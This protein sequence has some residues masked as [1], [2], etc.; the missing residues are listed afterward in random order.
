MHEMFKQ[1]LDIF[2]SQY[3]D[4]DVLLESHMAVNDETHK[5]KMGS[6]TKPICSDVGM[7][8]T[9]SAANLN[10][11]LTVWDLGLIWAR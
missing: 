1:Q 7:E 2:Q 11:E 8:S 5:I 10:N 4:E 3:K 6:Q 9:I